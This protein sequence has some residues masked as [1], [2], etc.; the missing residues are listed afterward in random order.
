MPLPLHCPC[1][2]LSLTLQAASTPAASPQKAGRLAAQLAATW[3]PATGQSTWLTVVHQPL[4]GSLV[5]SWH[6]TD[7][8]VQG[9]RAVEQ[10]GCQQ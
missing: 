4:E 6:W 1:A 5:F 3:P 9:Q 2:Q 7:L 8:L 10:G